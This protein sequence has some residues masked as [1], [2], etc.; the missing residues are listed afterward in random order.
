MLLLVRLLLFTLYDELDLPSL[1]VVYS[2][3]CTVLNSDVTVSSKV[4]GMDVRMELI[5]VII[6]SSIGVSIDGCL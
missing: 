1:A 3:T 6:L 4:V 2:I 5:C